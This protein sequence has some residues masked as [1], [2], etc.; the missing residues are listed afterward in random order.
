MGTRAESRLVHR[1]SAA[2]LFLDERIDDLE[3]VNRV[4]FMG[5]IYTLKAGL[6]GMVARG[7]GRVLMMSSMMAMYGEESDFIPPLPRDVNFASAAFLTHLTTLKCGSISFRGESWEMLL[8]Q[9]WAL[10]GCSNTT[11]SCP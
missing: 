1:T 9:Y 4:N 11:R 8:P 10:D 2:G 6:P 5:V 7:S 3:K